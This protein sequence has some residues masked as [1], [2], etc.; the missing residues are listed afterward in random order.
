MAELLLEINPRLK[1]KSVL[2]HVFVR[3]PVRVFSASLLF[4][5]RFGEVSLSVRTNAGMVPGLGFFR[6]D[7]AV[8]RP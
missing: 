6:Y 8:P 5:A 3:Y 2:G 7:T 1:K 4:L